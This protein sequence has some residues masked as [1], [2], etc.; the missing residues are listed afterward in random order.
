M[1]LKVGLILKHRLAL[2][3]QQSRLCLLGTGVTDIIATGS[4]YHFIVV[5][6]VSTMVSFL[7]AFPALLT[8][9]P[10]LWERTALLE[11]GLREEESVL[12]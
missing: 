7:A 12:M 4:R 3:S 6:V 8:C 9:S 1:L 5:V 2:S 10:W 11:T